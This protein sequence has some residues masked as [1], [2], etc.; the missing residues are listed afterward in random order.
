MKPRV[1]IPDLRV[2]QEARLYKRAA[3]LLL[4]HGRAEDS[5]LLWPATMN[6]ALAVELFLKSFLAIDDSKHIANIE[7]IDVYH[8]ALQ[9]NPAAKKARHNLSKLYAAIDSEHLSKIE[10][11]SQELRPGYAL[12]IMLREFELHFEKIRYSYEASAIASV[13]LALFELAEHM[14][15][16]CTRLL[17]TVVTPHN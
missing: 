8:G 3:N 16:I 12:A 1:F 2:V 5:E 17:P 6:A 14:D 11:Q 9:M 7:G 4:E 15:Q 10:A 13:R